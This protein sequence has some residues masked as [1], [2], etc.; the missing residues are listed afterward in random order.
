MIYTDRQPEPEIE[1]RLGARFLSLEE[2]LS[3][4]DFISL[5]VPLTSETRA[6]IDQAALRA[7][8]RTAFLVNTSRGP[9]VDT[10][11]LVKALQ[12]GWIAGAALDV[13]DPEPLPAGNPAR[14]WSCKLL[15]VVLLS[16]VPALT[17][18]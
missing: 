12:E 4:S 8:K 13:T 3:K 7:M 2:L 6:L 5:H 17:I 16:E 18:S 1:A 15:Q 11:A 9:V 14:F 10:E